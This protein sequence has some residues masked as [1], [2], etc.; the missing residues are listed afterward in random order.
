M[1]KKYVLSYFLCCSFFLV[2]QVMADDNVSEQQLI[3]QMLSTFHQAAAQANAEKYLALLT[4]NA[5]FLGTDA[6]ERWSKQQ[7]SE[8][9]NRYFSQG[10][11]WRYTPLEQ[12]VTVVSSSTASFDELLHNDK[13]GLCRSTGTAI[14]TP[15]GWKIVHYSLSIPLPNAIAESVVKQIK[16]YQQPQ[17]NP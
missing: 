2:N 13:Y 6:A 12:H 7:F 15:N 10:R 16:Q 9:V 3:K 8:F 4:D 17:S 1:L 11:G 14:K 5:V